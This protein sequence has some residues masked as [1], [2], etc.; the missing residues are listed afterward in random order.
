MTPAEECRKKPYWT[1][2]DAMIALWRTGRRKRDK[3]KEEVRYY[4]C[5]LCKGHPYHLTS[6]EKRKKA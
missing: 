4:R 1:Q 2:L 5:P 6:E 3:G